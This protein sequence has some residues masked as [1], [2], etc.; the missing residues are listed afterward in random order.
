MAETIVQNPYVRRTPKLQQFL[1]CKLI[2]LSF[3]TMIA[4][5]LAVM[6]CSA[7]SIVIGHLSGANANSFPFG[8]PYQSNPGTRFQ[9]AYAASDFAGL[10]PLSISSIDFFRAN[11]GLFA[12]GTYS[13]YFSTISAGIDS[14]SDSDFNSNL[15]SDNTL[16]A[17]VNLSGSAPSE[18]TINGNPFTYNPAAG[19]LLLDIIISPGGQHGSA[20][21]ATDPDEVGVFSRYHDFG[22]A[23]IGWGLVTEFDYT[24]V[25]EPSISALAGLGI[26][27]GLVIRYLRA[28]RNL[29]AFLAAIPPAHEVSGA[30]PQKFMV[31]FL[32]PKNLDRETP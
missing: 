4:L 18:L 31:N 9:Q 2:R 27:T 11:T 1:P 13:F 7:D 25:P 6:P 20:G 29:A 3:L 26:L 14:L 8:G 19:N 28:K 10:G 15:G 17:T 5:A 23:N 32:A 24:V 21:F 30:P 16:F 12:A 22:S